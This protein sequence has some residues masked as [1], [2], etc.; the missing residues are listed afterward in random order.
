MKNRSQRRHHEQ[1]V[2]QKIK[3]RSKHEYK[4]LNEKDIGKRAAVHGSMCSCF[5]CGNPRKYYNK[6][7][8]QEYKQDT[9]IEQ[10]IKEL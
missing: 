3:R 4:P 9:N 2:K 1:R 5:M 8:L 10:Q 6:K 7:T